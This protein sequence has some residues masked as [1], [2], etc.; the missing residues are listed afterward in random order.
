[1]VSKPDPGGADEQC[2]DERR[3]KNQA[4]VGR[5]THPLRRDQREPKPVTITFNVRK[6]INA[7]NQGEKL[8]I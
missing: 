8:R 3:P 2:Y 4:E 1:M 7:S 6:I 5:E